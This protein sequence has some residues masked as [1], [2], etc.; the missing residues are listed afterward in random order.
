MKYLKT[1]EK[2]FEDFNI[3]DYII[4]DHDIY[5][6]GNKIIVRKNYPY[7]IIDVY[8]DNLRRNIA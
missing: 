2:N 5:I 4:Y 7:I 1:F 6:Q 8:D 3:G